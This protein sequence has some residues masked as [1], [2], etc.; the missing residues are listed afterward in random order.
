MQIPPTEK[1]P[2]A[3]GGP[4]LRA[5]ALKGDPTA[6]YEIGVRFTEGKGVA[7]EFRRGREVV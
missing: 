1:L 4:V 5:A 2:D 7:V 3:I 6:A